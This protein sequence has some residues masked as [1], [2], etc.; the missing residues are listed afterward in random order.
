MFT[1]MVSSPTAITRDQNK[2]IVKIIQTLLAY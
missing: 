2:K 1:A